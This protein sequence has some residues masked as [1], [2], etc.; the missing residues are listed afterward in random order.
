VQLTST[1][2]LDSAHIMSTTWFYV[3]TLFLISVTENGTK[4]VR[5]RKMTF[6]I[7]LVRSYF[8]LVRF[9]IL[10]QFVCVF[11]KVVQ[12]INKQ[13]QIAVYDGGRLD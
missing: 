13:D 5:I 8:S 6:S 10:Q 11:R 3:A 4:L 1:V 12:T 7:R 2:K 9:Q